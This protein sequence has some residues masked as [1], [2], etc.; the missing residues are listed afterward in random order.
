MADHELFFARVVDVGPGRLR[1]PPLLYSS[2]LGWR[3]TGDE[4]REPGMQRPRRA[5]GP[6]APATTRRWMTPSTS[7]ADDWRTGTYR[8]VRL[9]A[10]TV[11]E[12][13]RDH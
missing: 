13:V 5:A 12:S 7:P 3:V 11:T 4:A 2:R 6:P 8:R 9:G 1:E 10:M